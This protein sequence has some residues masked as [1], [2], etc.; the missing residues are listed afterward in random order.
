M[1]RY[2]RL[3]PHLAV[4]ELGRRYLA[5]KELPVRSWYQ[6]LWLLARGPDRPGDRGQHGLFGLLDWAD[7]QTL[8]RRRAGWDD[9]P[10]IH[11][12]ASGGASPTKQIVLVLDRAG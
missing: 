1:P 6:I 12:L 4:N 10:A 8:Q 3:E 7:R 11:A 5:G 2:F 9:Q